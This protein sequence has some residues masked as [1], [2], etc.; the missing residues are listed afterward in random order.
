M[1]A[2]AAVGKQ[3]EQSRMP[4]IHGSCLCG[5]VAFEMTGTPQR[6]THCHCSRCRKV[7]GTAH[8]TNLFVVLPEI[9]F[10]RGEELLTSY[11]PPDARTFTHVFCRVCG[12]SMPR[13]DESR[14]IAVVPMGAFDDD[15]GARPE[16][17]IFVESKAS[18]EQISDDGLPR[19]PG[20][21]PPA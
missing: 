9:R 16:R 6:A 14:G 5:G 8:A 12:S 21:P 10:T 4:S 3:C 13:L 18:W 1:S 20:S 17:H 7:R 19:V 11:K 2:V 15:P